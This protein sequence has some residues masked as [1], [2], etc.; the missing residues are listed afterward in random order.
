MAAWLVF[1]ILV[2]SGGAWLAR[3]YA[4]HHALVDQPGE[5]RSHR[6]PTPRSGG[7]GIVAA[8][9]AGGAWLLH[10]APEAR[11]L[12]APA[13]AGFAAVATVGLVDDHR[14]LSPWFR[15]GVHAMASGL[16]AMGAWLAWQD[17]VWTAVAFLASMVL[18][19]VWNFMDGIDGIATTQAMLVATALAYAGAGTGGWAAWLSAALVA[20]C[21]GFLPFNFPKARLFLGDV[22][23]GAI[24]FMVA[25]LLVSVGASSAAPMQW[26]LLLLPSGFLID[27]GLTLAG[28]MWRGEAW[29]HPHALHAYQRWAR[30]AGSHVPVTLAYA[31]WTAAACWLASALQGREMFVVLAACAAWYIAGAAG[32]WML[33]GKGMHAVNED[34]T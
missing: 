8:V 28:R 31:G 21:A 9:L 30:R 29:W 6:V 27:A 23:S 25:T 33:Q 19:N 26:A 3:R 10:G 17:P 4:L 24:G 13:L 20:A 22:G 18:T 16:L 11:P 1:H 7:I 2:A 15:L 34:R 32:W 12:L 14:S 5:R